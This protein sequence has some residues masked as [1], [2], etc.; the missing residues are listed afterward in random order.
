M[1][2]NRGKK[3]NKSQNVVYADEIVNNISNVDTDDEFISVKKEKKPL[4]YA[5][6]AEKLANINNTNNMNTN[7]IKNDVSLKNASNLVINKDVRIDIDDKRLYVRDFLQ[8]YWY[9]V[10]RYHKINDIIIEQDSDD[11]LIY[12]EY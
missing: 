8:N 1:G 3:K 10:N 6:I 2:R 4:S 12:D 9:L 5:N 11:E 7:K